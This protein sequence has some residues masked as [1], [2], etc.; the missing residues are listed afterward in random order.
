MTKVGGLAIPS[1]ETVPP[2]RGLAAYLAQF[3]AVIM[4]FHP[5][6]VYSL[7]G[8]V[9]TRHVFICVDCQTAY[10]STNLDDVGAIVWQDVPYRTYPTNDFMSGITLHVLPVFL[11]WVGDPIPTHLDLLFLF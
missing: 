11:A 1:D 5:V 7:L 2:R 8:S 6:V 4:K 9:K 3:T 10:C